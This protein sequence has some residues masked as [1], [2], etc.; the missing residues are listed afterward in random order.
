MIGGSGTVPWG[1]VSR[2]V[3]LLL[4]VLLLLPGQDLDRG[5]GLPNSHS[6]GL[7]TAQTPTPA[8]AFTTKTPLTTD[9]PT[10]S[11][12]PS[13]KM[14][15]TTTSSSPRRLPTCR[16]WPRTW[17]GCRG[18]IGRARGGRGRDPFTRPEMAV[19]MAV[20]VLVTLPPAPQEGGQGCEEAEVGPV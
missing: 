6:D 15:I 12:A 8:E 10:S 2:P 1:A 16:R 14:G 7:L 9:S 17:R 13:N 3:L 4:V 19:S 5:R 11:E 18:S 20:V